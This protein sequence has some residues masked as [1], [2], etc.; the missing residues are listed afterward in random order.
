M[1]DRVYE[2]RLA[3]LIP[4]E[5]LVREIGEIESA[6]HEVHTVVSVSFPDQAAL[7]GFLHR[8]R[9]YGLEVLEVRRLVTPE[10]PR[11]RPSGR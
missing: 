8:L 4:A 6:E 3:G 11:Q 5:D 7:Q 10:I 2:V 9:A 1:S